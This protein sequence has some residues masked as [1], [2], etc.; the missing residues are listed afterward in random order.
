MTGKSIDEQLDDIFDQ[1]NSLFDQSKFE[2]CDRILSKVP[3]EET[4]TDLLL[5]YLTATLPARRSLPYRPEFYRKTEEI[6][7][8]RGEWEEG[9]LNG[10]E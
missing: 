9:L 3:I 6:I 5:G 2:E 7:R 4:G 8:K 1:C 10:L